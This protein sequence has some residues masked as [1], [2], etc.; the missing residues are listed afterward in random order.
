[1]RLRSTTEWKTRD[2]K[3]RTIRLYKAWRNIC[4]RVQ[5]HNIDGQ[6]NKRWEGIGNEFCNWQHFREWSLQNGFSKASNSCDR[7]RSTESYGPNNC[8]WV[9]IEY[10]TRCANAVAAENR[11]IREFQLSP[12]TESEMAEQNEFD[13]LCLGIYH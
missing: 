12:L 10:N 8:R 2:G 13:R 9:S 1:M 11:R 7:I 4:G 3:K 5:G 6:G